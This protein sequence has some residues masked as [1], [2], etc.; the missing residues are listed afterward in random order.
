MRSETR[1]LREVMRPALAIGPDE[2]IRMAAELMGAASVPALFVIDGAHVVGLLS[3]RD[4]VGKA[5]AHSLSADDTK[6][7]EIMDSDPVRISDDRDLP[8]ALIVMQARG[9]HELLVQDFTGRV[10]GIFCD[11]GCCDRETQ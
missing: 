11:C 6:V 5:V 9:V 1:R 8:S 3:N 7:S 2:S 10:V 4:L